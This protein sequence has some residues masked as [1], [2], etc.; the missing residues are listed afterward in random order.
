MDTFQPSDHA[1]PLQ[2]AFD[3]AWPV[4]TL[5]RVVGFYTQNEREY[6]RVNPVSGPQSAKGPRG[7][8]GLARA[9]RWPAW[10]HPVNQWGRP[11]DSRA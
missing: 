6:V 1:T 5:V 3:G 2:P 11:R 4:G 9:H 8:A 10:P 7:A